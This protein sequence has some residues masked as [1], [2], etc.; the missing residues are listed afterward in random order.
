[1]NRSI[2]SIAFIC[3]LACLLSACRSTELPSLEPY[4]I[5]QDW[6]ITVDTQTIWPAVD[7]WGAFETQELRDIIA[8]VQAT[9]TTLLNNERNLRT[10]QILLTQAGFNL[11]PT[12]VLTTAGALSYQ[13]VEVSEDDYFDSTNESYSLGGA[14]VYADI[15][16]KRDRYDAALAQYDASVARAA[17]TALNTLT[18]A[19]STY[20][21]VLLARDQ[22]ATAQQNLENAIVISDILQ[23]RFEAGV[24]NEVDALQQEIAVEQQRNSVRNFVQTEL[25]ARASLAILLNRSVRDFEIREETLETIIVPRVMPGVPAELLVRRPDLVQAEANLRS[26]RA[27]VDLARIA[28][29]PNISLTASA[30]ARSEDLRELVE[31]PE[32]IVN[33]LANIAFT[34]LDNG[35]RSR[36]LELTRL[37]LD[38]QFSEYRTAVIR[39]FNEIDVALSNIELLKALAKVALDDRA[40]AEE[41]FRIAEVRYREGVTEYQSVLNA[42]TALY[43]ARPRYLDNKLARLNAIIALYRSLGGGW[44]APQTS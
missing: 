23:A 20:F 38:S 5:P 7:W 6:Q 42:Q 8:D 32:I 31:S 27:N 22:I 25:A 37:E 35:T 17:D 9:N 36:S 10:A 33:G 44:V 4:D 19:A 18:F 1:M 14:L 13:G 43:R 21:R 40:K 15:L 34:I 30:D 3:T 39:A 24:I 41:S 12:A 28:F 16:S 2:F 29:L 26:Q 11:Y